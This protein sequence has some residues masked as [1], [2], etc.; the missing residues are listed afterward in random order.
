MERNKGDTFL[1]LCPVRLGCSVRSP[2]GK[3]SCL[4][5]V[6]RPQNEAQQQGC[7]ARC[8]SAVEL[9]FFATESVDASL[10]RIPLQSPQKASGRSEDRP[11][12]TKITL[13]RW[14]CA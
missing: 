5:L 9:P 4:P 11:D 12:G 7:H 2:A 1:P 6:G 13:A 14:W 10:A 3:R 8:F